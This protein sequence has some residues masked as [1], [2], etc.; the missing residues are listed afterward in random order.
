MGLQNKSQAYR[1]EFL[2][3]GL[4]FMKRAATA[5]K[6]GRP[7]NMQEDINTQIMK[8]RG[9]KARETAALAA[10]PKST[11]AAATGIRGTRRAFAI[12]D[13]ETTGRTLLG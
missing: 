2:R 12:A 7:Y 4:G 3:A 5:N 10:A 1:Q 8:V 11:G 9:Q 6:E 13:A